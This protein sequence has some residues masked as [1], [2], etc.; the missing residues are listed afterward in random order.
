MNLKDS[1][2]RTTNL[3]ATTISALAGFAFL[4]EVFVEDKLQ[5]KL[6]DALLFVLGIVAMGWYMKGENRFS[7]SVL[8]V[9]FV[10]AGLLI[11][12][13]GVIIEI[14]EKDDVGDDFGGLILFLLGSFFVALVYV[15]SKKLLAAAR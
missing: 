15:K 7:R 6:D 11:K 8:P 5:Y 3:A 1:I 9:L 14:K 4:P 13:L 2:N 12:F 10:F